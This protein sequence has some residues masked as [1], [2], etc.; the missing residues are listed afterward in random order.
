MSWLT[1]L[2]FLGLIGLIILIIIYII[3][4]NYQNKIISSTFVWKLSLKYK[5]N[6]I[7]I[8]KLRNI[9]LLLCQIF[10]ITVSSLILAQPFIENDKVESN[11]KVFIIDASASMTT[12]FAGETRFERAVNMVRDE[13]DKLLKQENGQVS[14]ILAGDKAKYLVNRATVN[15]R[16]DI[17][18]ELDKLLDPAEKNPCTYAGADITGAIK[19]SENVTAIEDN[20]EVLLFTDSHYIDAG[21]VNVVSV[22][23]DMEWNAAI[24][25]VRARIVENRYEIEI[26]VA[27]YGGVNRDIELECT[28]V[29][30]D[31]YGEAVNETLTLSA[32]CD[33]D[34]IQ[35]VVLHYL[36]E[37]DKDVAAVLA[38][39]QSYS[40][41]Y[42]SIPEDDNLE[43][44]NSFSLYG[45]DKPTLKIQYCSSK[46][47]NYF[48]TALKVLRDRLGYRWNIEFNEVIMFEEEEKQLEEPA[49]EG[50]DMYIYEH[51]MPAILPTDGVVLLVNPN[52][53]PAGA[54]FKVTNEFNSYNDMTLSSEETETP[55]HPLLNKINPEL[56]TVTKHLLI[57]NPDGYD[58]LLFCNGRPVLLAKNEPEEKIAV[59]GFSLNFSNLPVILEFP[60]LMYNLI[61][62]YMPSTITEY[63]FDVND[64]VSLNSRSEELTVTGAGNETTVTEF[65]YEITLTA[66]GTYT[67]IQTPISGEEVVETFFVKMPSAESNINAQIDVLNNPYY[68]QA[69]ENTSHEELLLYFAIA[70]V[71][72]LF[73]EWWLHTRE[74]F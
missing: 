10:A 1:P 70:L 55:D 3:K 42:V 6:K 9:L 52:E 5:K 26:D 58:Q 66:P 64:K 14:I 13:V 38:D 33:N 24:L 7:P 46:P 32:R 65:P 28:I 43:I 16:T 12:E 61:E 67:V 8:S 69:E 27:C 11:N 37:D 59:L 47:N 30:T 68:H 62:Y 29:G 39:L 15:S 74:Q 63:V 19:L 60:M 53:A 35:T 73:A 72:L 50:Y 41:I 23:N 71:T 44:D 36:Y 45:G 34:E 20:V 18:M 2:G 17:Y 22:R 25:D 40:S 31:I 48:D 56:I 57:D 54:G 21:K 4:P 51:M 49:T